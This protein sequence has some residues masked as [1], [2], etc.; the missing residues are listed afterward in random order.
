MLHTLSFI[1]GAYHG[2]F[3]IPKSG[4]WNCP[5]IIHWKEPRVEV[6]RM[7]ALGPLGVGVGWL[8]GWLYNMVG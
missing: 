2:C 3:F 1:D 5:N 8:I 4:T 6:E 7:Q